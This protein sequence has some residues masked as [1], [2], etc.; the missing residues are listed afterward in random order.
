MQSVKNWLKSLPFFPQADFY[1]RRLLDSRL[2]DFNTRPLASVL[3]DWP[4][5]LLLDIT[6]RCNAKCLWCPNPELENLGAMSMDLYKKII[7]NYGERGGIVI[8]GT[9]GEPLMDK[10]MRERLEFIQQFPKIHK[11]E[12]LTNAFFLN[13]T[14]TPVL[15]DNGAGVDISLDELDKETFETVKKMSFDV[16]R[17]N[18]LAFLKANQKAARPVPVNIRIKTLRTVEE[19]LENDFFKQLADSQCSIVLNSID[20]NI[21]SNWA[22]T[23]DK[24]AFLKERLPEF[25][26]PGRYTHK[27]YNETNV[28][29]CAQLWKWLVVYWN[30]NVVLCCADMFSKSSVGNLETQSIEQVWQGDL[31]AGYRN[32]MVRRERFD[33]PLCQNCDI[34]LSWHNLK[35]YYDPGGEYLRDRKFIM[36]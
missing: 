20:D 11:I 16:V 33:V 2:F 31:M 27:R 36:G 13:E 9:F 17:D 21:I 34:H 3:E 14:I 24:Q 12:I 6:N 28:A 22:G 19:T 35:D 29:P 32:K 23:F 25:R 26:G 15:I 7:R 10:S 1:R 30:G 8:F 5:A 4:G 18:I